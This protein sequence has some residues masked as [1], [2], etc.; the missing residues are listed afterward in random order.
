VRIS[1]VLP[2]LVAIGSVAQAVP[3]VITFDTPSSPFVTGYN[4]DHNYGGWWD[5]SGM[6]GNGKWMRFCALDY[7]FGDVRGTVIT[8]DLKGNWASNTGTSGVGVYIFSG[9]DKA[10]WNDFTLPAADTGD[11]V[12]FTQSFTGGKWLLDG[13]ATS[14]DDVL[15]N[16]THIELMGAP[17][18]PFSYDNFGFVPEPAIAPMLCAAAIALARRRRRRRE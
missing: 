4:L 13:D 7:P 5:S 8:I 18:T 15:S 17:M 16:V 10:I 14:V 11:F 9:P 1:L 2:W 6:P 12:T 3:I